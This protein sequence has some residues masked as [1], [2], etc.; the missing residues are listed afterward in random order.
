MMYSHILVFCEAT[1]GPLLTWITFEYTRQSTQGGQSIPCNYPSAMPC[2][3]IACPIVANDQHKYVVELDASANHGGL[4][5]V[6]Y[7]RN[8]RRSS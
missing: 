7:A 3:L 6:I 4:T 2:D 5:H 8:L 1:A